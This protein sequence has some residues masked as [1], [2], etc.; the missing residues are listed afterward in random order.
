VD[1][2]RADLPGQRFIVRSD[3][4]LMAFLKLDTELTNALASHYQDAE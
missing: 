3:D 2:H 1:A 4:L